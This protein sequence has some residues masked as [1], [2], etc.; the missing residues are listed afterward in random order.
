MTLEKLEGIGG[1]NPIQVLHKA[2]TM[3]CILFSEDVEELPNSICAS[4]NCI[5]SSL[6]LSRILVRVIS[7]VLTGAAMG[8]MMVVVLSP[9][10]LICVISKGSRSRAVLNDRRRCNFHL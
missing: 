10:S 3:A 4:L 7:L 8:I 6:V 5:S 9:S 1:I 2:G